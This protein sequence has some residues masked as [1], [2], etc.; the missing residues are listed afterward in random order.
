M[1]VQSTVGSTERQAA[2]CYDSRTLSEGSAMTPA[3]Q[4]SPAVQ[5]S[6]AR[7]AR[8]SDRTAPTVFAGRDE[9][10][11]LLN[12]AVQGVREGENG[13]TVVIHGVPGAGKSALI[14]EFAARSF[15]RD[16]SD[17]GAV[18]PVI[19]DPGSLDSTPSALVESIDAGF[20]DIGASSKWARTMARVADGATY[21]GNAVFAAAT[22]QRAGTF[23]PSAKAPNSLPIALR[24]YVD[25]RFGRRGNTI[26]LLVDE[27]QNLD[28]TPTVRRHLNVLH[29][30]ITGKSPVLLACFGLG[31]TVSRL[32]ELGLSRL[33]SDHVRTLGTLS[34]DDAERV[35]TGTLNDTFSD[36]A[37]G[38]AL[39]SKWIDEAA[40]SI[41]KESG[42]FPHHLTN[43]C[44]ALA[45]IVLDEGIADSPPV[46]R[47][48]TECLRYRREYY[49]AR[50]APWSRYQTTLARAFAGCDGGGAPTK[51]VVAALTTVE[52]RGR[53]VGEETA[54]EVVEGLCD[55]GF[56]AEDGDTLK[57]LLPSLLS[58][59]Q[60][61]HRS[62]APNELRK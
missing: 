56:L 30:G 3:Q 52:R 14:D 48:R 43:G 8:T 9:E 21:L 36:H 4:L 55:A 59:F 61:V 53:P 2:P 10:L 17:E 51:A 28:D 34:S 46:A 50:L 32:A 44:R 7:L 35:V 49:D 47:L 60:D 40:S 24:E 12:D 58:H 29:Q 41:L 11:A 62:A 5:A 22:K 23:A 25:F 54:W 31:K 42:G 13:H 26:V 20:R 16:A 18:V 27:S 45:K 1:V 57:P 37:F 6:L 15:V 38:N 39:R 33:A 19:L